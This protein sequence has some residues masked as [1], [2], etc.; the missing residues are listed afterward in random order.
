[1]IV[2]D[3]QNGGFV[4]IPIMAQ[5]SKTGHSIRKDA[6]SIPGLSIWHCHKLKRRSQIWLIPGIAVSVA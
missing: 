4:G 1:M 3:F 6:S 2:Y 5:W